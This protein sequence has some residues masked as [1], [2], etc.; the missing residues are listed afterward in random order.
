MACDVS[1]VAMFWTEFKVEIKSLKVYRFLSSWMGEKNWVALACTCSTTLRRHQFYISPFSPH[2]SMFSTKVRSL[3]LQMLTCNFIAK[4]AVLLF[5][6]QQIWCLHSL[7][8]LWC[9]PTL[10]CTFYKVAQFSTEVRLSNGSPIDSWSDQHLQTKIV[11]ATVIF[12]RGWQMK[13]KRNVRKV[14][15]WT[16]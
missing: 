4:I 7:L 3:D 2:I 5:C 10:S 13:I 15:G 11:G 14:V 1:P 6:R 9:N 16:M 8:F 12:R